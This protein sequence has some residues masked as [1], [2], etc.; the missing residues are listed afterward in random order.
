MEE[1]GEY[2]V[3][4]LELLQGDGEA[5]RLER[6][7]ERLVRSSSGEYTT[8]ETPGWIKLGVAFRYTLKDLKGPPLAV[9]LAICLHINKDG[10]AWPGI[11][12]LADITGYDKDTVSGALEKLESIPGLL[13]IAHRAGP[14][15]TNVYRPAF[16]AYGKASPRRPKNPDTGEKSASGNYAQS[17][18]AD[19][20]SVR[21][22]AVQRPVLGGSA[23]GD[24]AQSPDRRREKKNKEEEYSAPRGRDLLFDAIAHVCGIDPSIQGNGSSIG[25]VKADLLKAEPPYTPE[26]VLAWGQ[27]QSW[28]NTPP[29]VWQLKQ[30]IGSIRSGKKNGHKHSIAPDFSKLSAEDVTRINAEM[31]G[32]A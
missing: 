12:T 3:E 7:S 8:E 16:A 22:R 4:A 26:E 31:N 9:F 19:G 13:Q 11:R 14:R 28:R 21:V 29:T 32:G 18:D 5:M 25:K 24:Y 27:S 23:S 30:G 2:W 15:G 6:P 17:P 10:A 20:A 1:N